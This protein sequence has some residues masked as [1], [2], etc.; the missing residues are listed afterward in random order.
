MANHYP[1]HWQGR[2][3]AAP[4]RSTSLAFNAFNPAFV[5][6]TARCPLTPA[7]AGVH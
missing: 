1:M 4:K 2:P 7:D 5:G 6:L 3:V